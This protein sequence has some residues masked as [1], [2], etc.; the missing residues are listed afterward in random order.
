MKENNYEEDFKFKPM[1]TYKIQN[2]SSHTNIAWHGQKVLQCSRDW[3]TAQ[4]PVN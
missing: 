2:L 3:D 4:F 1:T